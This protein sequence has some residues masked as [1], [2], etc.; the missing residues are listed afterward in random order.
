LIRFQWSSV[1]LFANCLLGSST[2]NLREVAL[3]GWAFRHESI[4]L[5]IHR[6]TVVLGPPRRDL[7]L[8]IEQVLKP[9]HRQALIS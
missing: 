8:R 1:H 2:G 5:R 6:C 3:R 9:A 7:A 4:M